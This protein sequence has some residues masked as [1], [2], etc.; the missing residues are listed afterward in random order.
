[1]IARAMSTRKREARSYSD[2]ARGA[3]EM[4]C[5]LEAKAL[6]RLA[7]HCEIQ[8]D[9]AAELSFFLDDDRPAVAGRV[10]LEVGLPCQW[11]DLTLSRRVESSFVA[12]LAADEETAERWEHQPTSTLPSTT[13]A[14]DADAGIS[15]VV[16]GPR[17]NAAQLVED[18]LLM[19][20]P[21]RVC[22]DLDC[23]HR[24]PAG[25][26]GQ[27]EGQGDGASTHRP[28]DGLKALLE[29]SNA[30]DGGTRE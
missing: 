12:L 11:C 24:P 15:I 19:A 10:A 14:V 2:L 26:G 30:P 3:V 23:A 8:S 29:A 6:Q 21:A 28:F 16:S 18:E 4:R 9:A 7:E 17:L 20:L 25:Y 13:S 5:S 27:K 1:M 22:V